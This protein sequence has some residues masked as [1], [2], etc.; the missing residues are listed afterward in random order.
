MAHDT[1]GACVGADLEG[2]T[3]GAA[4]GVKFSLDMKC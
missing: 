1:N 4:P 3:F 2:L